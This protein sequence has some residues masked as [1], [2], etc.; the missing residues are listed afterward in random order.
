[1]RS[2]SVDAN[3]NAVRIALWWFEHKDPYDHVRISPRL[4]SW[5]LFW[6]PPSV[7]SSELPSC[8]HRDAGS[9]HRPRFFQRCTRIPHSDQ[10]SAFQS[11]SNHRHCSL[12]RFRSFSTFR[13]QTLLC[14]SP[15]RRICQQ[16]TFRLTIHLQKGRQSV[17][18]QF[19]KREEFQTRL[20]CRFLWVPKLGNAYKHPQPSLSTFSSKPPSIQLEP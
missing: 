19:L 6:P 2:L 4:W 9:V 14:P 10:Q 12:S 16:D 18:Q 13:S 15:S 5:R 20:L 1:M 7:L 3:R 17:V 8:H 11:F